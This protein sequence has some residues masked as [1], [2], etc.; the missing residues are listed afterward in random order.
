MFLNN[1]DQSKKDEKNITMS[2]KINGKFTDIACKSGTY[3]EVFDYIK[4]QGYSNFTVKNF[5]NTTV[6][7]WYNINESGKCEVFFN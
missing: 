6:Y 4:N 5:W 3:K 1:S 2:L 7:S